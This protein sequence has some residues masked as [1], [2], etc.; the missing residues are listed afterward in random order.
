MK[1]LSREKKRITG[2]KT[3][4]GRERKSPIRRQTDRERGS[5]QRLKVESGES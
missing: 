4:E 3:K 5:E 2:D 1:T